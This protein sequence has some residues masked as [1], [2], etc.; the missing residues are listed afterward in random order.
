MFD[1]NVEKIHCSH[2]NKE[3][4]RNDKFVFTHYISFN[5]NINHNDESKC[6]CCIECAKLDDSTLETFINDMV[7]KNYKSHMYSPD[8]IFFT[9][10]IEK[11]Y[12]RP[13]IMTLVRVFNEF[14]NK[15]H[16]DRIFIE[17]NTTLNKL[18]ERQEEQMKD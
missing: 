10:D 17:L 16:C 7:I 18:K 8:T 15:F 12:E 11:E 9:D 3:I 6:F 2:C 5:P 1:V 14:I 4:G 13:R